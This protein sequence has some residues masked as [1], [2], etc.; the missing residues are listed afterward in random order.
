MTNHFLRLEPFELSLGGKT[1]NMSFSTSL[2]TDAITNLQIKTNA[3]SCVVLDWG[4]GST[5]Q[6][7][8][9]SAIESP[10]VTN[11][12]TAIPA[13]CTNR[14][15]NTSIGTQFYS[16]PTSIS[17]GTVIY[18]ERIPAGKGSGGTTGN[19]HVWVLKPSTSYV[20]RITN[21]GNQTTNVSGGLF[22]AESIFP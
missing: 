18:S 20:W 9:I 21:V 13:Y 14:V 8:T 6:P 3:K 4:V 10:T 7:V 1:F 2:A 12:T 22:F 19:Q 5:D 16:D 11:G 15:F 17:G